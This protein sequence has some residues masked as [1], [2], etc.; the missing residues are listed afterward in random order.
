MSN[1]A[2]QER[3][4][5]GSKGVS[6]R[7]VLQTAGA[8]GVAAAGT[9]LGLFGGKAPAF[10]QSREIHLVTFPQFAGPEDTYARV[11]SE[12]E[13]QTGVKVKI[14]KIDQNNIVAR[15]TAV[16]ESG[17][18][19]DMSHVHWNQAQLWAGGLT[20]HSDLIEE[21][22][23]GE[24]Y[25]FARQA[26]LDS[27]GVYRGFPY[28]WVPVMHSYRKDIFAELGIERFPETMEEYLEAGRKLKE[29]GMPVGF[30]LG[31][32]VGDA[33]SNAYPW[34]WGFGAM[35]V[36]ADQKV[37]IDSAETRQ[38]LEFFREFWDAACDPAGLAYDDGTNNR[39]WMGERIG[40]T[41]NATSIY[42]Y[43]RNNPDKVPEGMADNIGH[44]LQPAGPA[45]RYHVLQPWNY[46]IFK[47]SKNID[48]C[49]EFIR[50]QMQDDNYHEWLDGFGGFAAGITPKWEDHP[51]WNDPAL[52]DVPKSARF[53]RN[54]GHAGPMDRKAM[55]SLSKYIVVD[56]LARLIRGDSVDDAVA[57]GAH[58]L[59]QV[60]ES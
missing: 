35:E 23:G 5:V 52:T 56:L 45:G 29:H 34:L 50:V 7:T 25:E 39:A 57:W 9:G 58:E 18:G 11:A 51:I 43:A 32:T 37:A 2:E 1:K 59:K 21:L 15:G 8:A 6:R 48:A 14:E 42:W 31:H 13:S 38:A 19:A 30:T 27:D 55:E 53:G 3:T 17:S 36:D 10:A 60:Y 46:V 12:F 47:S 4:D 16:I 44:G 22:G 49:K 28:V 20:D 41:I 24:I 40:L 33:P 26:N 54:F